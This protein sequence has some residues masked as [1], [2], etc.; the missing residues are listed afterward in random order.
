LSRRSG[1]EAIG[2]AEGAA[3]ADLHISP[4]AFPEFWRSQNRQPAIASHRYSANASETGLGSVPAS[5]LGMY[6]KRFVYI[7]RSDVDPDRHYVGLTSDV[8]RRLARHNSGPSGVTVHQRPWSVVVSFEF[9]DPKTARR[10]E[11]YLKTGSGRAF[12]KR[13]FGGDG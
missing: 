1:A 4:P 8:E 3:K 13:H 5:A 7:L 10:F 11:R 6:A 9:A 12:A 2:S